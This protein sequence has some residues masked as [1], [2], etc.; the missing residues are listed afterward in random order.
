MASFNKVLLLGNLTRDPELRHTP[1]GSPVAEFGLAVNETYKNKAGETVEQTCFAEI[2]VWGRQAETC[3]EFLK[4]GSNAFIEGK[5]QFEQWETQQGEKRN[6]LKVRADRVQ[7]IGGPNSSSSG[8]NS[9]PNSSS[10][11]DDLDAPPF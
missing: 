9:K 1:T 4:K 8:D 2:V 5:L 7:F 6:K 3:D 10:N 11:G